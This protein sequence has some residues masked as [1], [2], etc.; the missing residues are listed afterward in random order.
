[1]GSAPLTGSRRF[2]LIATAAL[3]VMLN[4][5]NTSM[6]SVALVNIQSEFQV[7]FDDISWLIATYYIASAIA[8]PVMGKLSDALGP[9]LVFA[10]GIALVTLSSILAPTSDGMGELLV[11]RIIQA[12]GTSAFQPAGMSII[13]Q[14]VTER[15][16]QASSVVKFF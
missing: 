3:G 14:A 1:M 12:V 13:R 8:Q 10:C 15:Q 4:P 16:A 5:L 6:I 9:K 7:G 2:W 11:Y